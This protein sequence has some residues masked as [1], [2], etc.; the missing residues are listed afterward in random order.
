MF[1]TSRRLR[2]QVAALLCIP[3]SVYVGILTQSDTFRY[4]LL[5]AILIFLVLKLRSKLNID[6]SSALAVFMMAGAALAV[7]QIVPLPLPSVVSDFVAVMSKGGGKEA[8]HEAALRESLWA[9][10]IHRGVFNSW[11]LGLGPGPHL[12]MPAEIV[13]VRANYG[14]DAP[15]NTTHPNANGTANFEAHNTLFDLFTQGGLLAIGSF[16]WLLATAFRRAFTCGRSGL[17]AL[18]AGF[19]VFLVPSDI[20]RLPTLWFGLALCL[21]TERQPILRPL[22]RRHSSLNWNSPSN[23]LIAHVGATPSWACERVPIRR[24]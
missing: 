14:S 1:D 19:G 6:W 10:A 16:I 18:L 13:E 23:A 7:T 3:A 12:V 24:S 9:Q 2:G 15:G 8:S 11:L 5:V 17:I 20:V 21:V 4:A 22:S